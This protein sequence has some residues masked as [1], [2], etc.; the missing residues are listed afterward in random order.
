MSHWFLGNI[1]VRYG[2]AFPSKIIL[3]EIKLFP[4][5]NDFLDYLHS[6][7]C[8][9]W[10]DILFAFRL[11]CNCRCYWTTKKQLIFCTI[12]KQV[13]IVCEFV[14]GV[15]EP[16]RVAAISMSHRVAEEMNLP[17]SI[18]SYKIRFEKDC[19]PNT[20]IKFMTDGTLMREL[21]DDFL[22]M[23]YSVIILDEAHERSE[24][25]DILI[26][27]LSRIVPLRKK[28]N[29]MPLKLVIMSATLR[30]EDFINKQLFKVTPPVVNIEGRQFPV[31]AHFQ[32]KT[33]S[34][35]EYLKAAYKRICKVHR[36]L[37]PGAMLVFVTGKDEI[38]IL[39]AW[40]GNTFPRIG[41]NAASKP[42]GEG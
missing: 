13:L 24:F 42:V 39:S 40:L 36:T 18:V 11:S 27:L 15:T 4:W 34:E 14:S 30:I 2:E 8:V 1:Y 38:N 26:S 28:R 7:F 31:T 6:F 3:L 25:T 35:N 9:G 20:R 37:P 17:N 12:A 21:E 16:R 33:P 10:I 29:L 41:A 23:S 19:G 5:R 32:K 22:L